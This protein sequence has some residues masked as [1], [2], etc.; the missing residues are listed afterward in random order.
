MARLTPDEYAAFQAQGFLHIDPQIPDHVLDGVLA[1][2][3]GKYPGRTRRE[4]F[5]V[6]LGRPVIRP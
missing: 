6:L 5:V 4:S 2:L 1:D 3:H